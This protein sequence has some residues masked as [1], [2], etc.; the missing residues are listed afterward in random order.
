MCIIALYYALHTLVQQCEHYNWVDY[1]NTLNPPVWPHCT[2]LYCTLLY[3]TVLYFY[4]T[5]LYYTELYCTVVTCGAPSQWRLSDSAPSGRCGHCWS[6]GPCSTVQ[7]STVQYSIIY[8]S[9]I[10]HITVQYST[11][12]WSIDCM[13]HS[14]NEGVFGVQSSQMQKYSPVTMQISFIYS[15][16]IFYFNAKIMNPNII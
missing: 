15:H 4:C 11:V 9:K 2:V 14:T 1:R 7:Y 6:Q 13:T 3:C 5:A 16:T 8:Y 10:Q 12:Q